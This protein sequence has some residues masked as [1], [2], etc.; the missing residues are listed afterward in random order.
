[1]LASSVGYRIDQCCEGLLGRGNCAIFFDFLADFAILR[2]FDKFGSGTGTW[3][4]LGTGKYVGRV[5]N[6]GKFCH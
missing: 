2:D 5:V 1:V 4:S 3:L 6:T